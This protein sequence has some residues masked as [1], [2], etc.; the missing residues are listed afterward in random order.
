MALLFPVEVCAANA[1]K[2]HMEVGEAIAL[3]VDFPINNAI[4]GHKAADAN[5]RFV[6]PLKL[7]VES[8]LL[9]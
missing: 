6:P 7:L 1:V 9:K 8:L 4:D 5:S 3:S 2:T